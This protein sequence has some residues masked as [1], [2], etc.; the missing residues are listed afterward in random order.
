MPRDRMKKEV[1]LR[2]K[3]DIATERAIRQ[4]EKR[5]KRER[6]PG[7]WEVM[8]KEFVPSAERIHKTKLH[9]VFK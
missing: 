3:V 2:Q 4:T 9:E 5:E 1:Y 6:K 7:E 8:R